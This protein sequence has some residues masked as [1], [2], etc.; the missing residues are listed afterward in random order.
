MMLTQHRPKGESSMR[1]LKLFHLAAFGLFAAAILVPDH[2]HAQAQSMT[3][4]KQAVA[5]RIQAWGDAIKKE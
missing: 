1:K 4:Y 3:A 2:A 5:Q